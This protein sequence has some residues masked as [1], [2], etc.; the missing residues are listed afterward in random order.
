MIQEEQLIDFVTP[1]YIDKDI[2][3]DLS[4]I[5]RVVQSAKKLFKYY[6]SANEEI[7]I[8]A[9]HFHGFIYKDEAAI[10]QFL[11]DRNVEESLVDFIC[12]V[13]WES[14][15]DEEAQSLEGRIL[16]DAHLIEGG[17]TYIIV[18]CL[19]TGTARG[20]T[21][22]ET[23]DIIEQRILGRFHCYLPEAKEIYKEMHDFAEQFIRDL[24]AGLEEA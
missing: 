23:I 10:R 15:K 8:L 9:A 14:Q 1:Y 22:E 2:M 4:H 12:K 20:Q 21:L 11:S 24:K 13:A 6:P 16:H 19:V 7:I 18:K 3:H 5:R 17:K